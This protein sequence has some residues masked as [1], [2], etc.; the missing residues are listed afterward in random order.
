[1]YKTPILQAAKS[2]LSQPNKLSLNQ[3]SLGRFT[4][5][6]ESLVIGPRR[7]FSC[8]VKERLPMK[9]GLPPSERKHRD[10]M[11]QRGMLWCSECKLFHPVKKFRK[12]GPKK[13]HTN[14]GYRFYCNDCDKAQRARR[15]EQA[16]QKFN[17]RNAALKAKFVTL[18]GGVCH[19]CGYDGFLSAFDFH[20]VYPAEKKFT[21]TYVIYC[22]NFEKTWKELDKCCLLC[23]NCH[24]AYEARLWQA[25][26]I[27]RP[28]ALGWT[29]GDPLPL[30][31]SRYETEKP[32]KYQQASMPIFNYEQKA[33]QL[34]LFESRSAYNVGVTL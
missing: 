12:Y 21:P 32:P 8:P 7:L 15:K 18:A 6:L 2:C 29:V 20:H 23:S 19:R 3:P 34:T 14:Y 4:L 31:D 17:E 11:F 28:D 13:P 27:K 10:E 25:E 1:M 16:H 9:Y 30:D 33:S 5:G 22:G 26:F 24:N